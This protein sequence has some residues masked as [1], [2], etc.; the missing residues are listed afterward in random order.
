MRRGQFLVLGVLTA[1][2]A[3]AC[4][5]HSPT[6]PDIDD[7]RPAFASSAQA[8]IRSATI[9]RFFCFIVFR[10]DGAFHGYSGSSQTVESSS[11]DQLYKCKTDLSFGSPPSAVINL[12]GVEL[13]FFFPGR[14]APCDARITPSQGGQAMFICHMG[15]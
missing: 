10:Y 7:A 11:G 9:E 13:P 14:R 2:T 15:D 3:M 12:K 6:G 8:E 1:L 4:S 5:E